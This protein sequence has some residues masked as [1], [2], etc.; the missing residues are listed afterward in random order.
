[1]GA[2]AVIALALLVVAAASTQLSSAAFTAQKSNPSN[3]F[4]AAASFCNGSTQTLT[5]TKDAYVDQG[6]P[7][8]NFGSGNTLS[9]ESSAVNLISLLGN[10]RTLVQFS[11]P[12]LPQFCSVTSATLT[13]QATSAANG[14]TIQAF[15]ANGSWTET[16][17]TWNNQP[18]TS[19]SAAT[20]ASG[21][22]ARTWTVTSQVQ[23]MYSG[24]NNGFLLKDSSE[25]AAL[26]Q[27]QTY[28]SREGTPDSQDPQLSI[29]FG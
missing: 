29:T 10:R 12:S 7:A 20:S 4:T 8:A 11:L 13:L 22:G 25:G 16:G 24:T 6:Q 18:A 26:P 15:Q 5:A 23:G 2:R 14:R 3:G 17:V 28:Q 9:V 21:S 27:T 1:V 19:G